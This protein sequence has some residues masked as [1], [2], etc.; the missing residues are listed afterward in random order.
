M[1]RGEHLVVE[2]S[3][4][5]VPFEHH[6]IDMGDGTV[7]HLAPAQGARVTLKDSTDRFAVRRVSFAEFADGR[8]VRVRQHEKGR[9]PETVAASA[10]AMLGTTGYCLFSNNCEHFA[11]LC[12]TGRSESLQ[13]E[14]STATVAT[15]TSA[16]T[17]TFWT[18]TGRAGTQIALRGS[19]RGAVK[20]HP[21]ALMADGVEL[22]VLVAGCRKGMSVDR[23]KRV[24]RFSGNMAAIGVG[25]LIGGPVGAAVGLATHTGSR[26][27]ADQICNS[28]R[29]LFS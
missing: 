9:A 16:A 19:V 12:A 6:G 21:A 15:L 24:A 22:A 18:L 8:P 13:I 26:V 1:A 29:R 20:L 7:V 27:V 17:K 10:E 28:V 14:M 23:S 5:G 25:A 2:G 3:F 4:S 11:M